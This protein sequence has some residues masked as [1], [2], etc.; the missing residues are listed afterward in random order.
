MRHH[1]A[2]FFTPAMKHED[3]VVSESITLQVLTGIKDDDSE[4]AIRAFMKKRWPRIK[5]TTLRDYIPFI[6]NLCKVAR[7]LNEKE[8]EC[9]P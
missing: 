1:P 7:A 6:Q 4:E 9:P 3:V 5:E 2:D 8:A